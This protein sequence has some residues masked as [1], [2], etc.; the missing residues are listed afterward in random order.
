[1]AFVHPSPWTGKEHWDGAEGAPLGG[2][3]FLKHGENTIDPI[4]PKDVAGRTFFSIFQSFDTG[5]I[6]QKTAKLAQ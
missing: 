1:M 6:I 3:F 2:V 5:D 4:A